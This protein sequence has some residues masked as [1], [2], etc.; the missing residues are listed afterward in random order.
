MQKE[1]AAMTG[2]IAKLQDSLSGKM[3]KTEN[4]TYLLSKAFGEANTPLK[5]AG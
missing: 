3:A 1:T 2:D 5:V 4:Q